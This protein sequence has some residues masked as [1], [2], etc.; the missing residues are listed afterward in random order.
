MEVI[1]NLS[2]FPHL[3]S[4]GLP[5][6]N[7]GMKSKREVIDAGHLGEMK[8]RW[9]MRGFG[10]LPD[11]HLF[12]RTQIAK[13]GKE[14]IPATW[15][16]PLEV[17]LE[18][19][20]FFYPLFDIIKEHKHTFP[21]AYGL[22]MAN[23]GMVMINEMISRHPNSKYVMTDW[24]QFDK[25]IP[26]WLIRDAFSI[27]AS[28]I[29]FDHLD[30]GGIVHHVRSER[31]IRRWKLLINYSIDTPI[32]TCKGE[33]FLISGGVPSGSC[34]T[35]LIDS[36]INALVTRYL[37]YETTGRYAA[38]EIF[39]GDDGVFVVTRYGCGCFRKVWHDLERSQKLCYNQSS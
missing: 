15:G 28:L 30:V 11:V 14:K 3:K 24:S 4:P 37:L 26:P 7:L 20:R 9:A 35:N 29:D 25:T 8:A 36:V 16:F 33:R 1:P 12:G 13:I 17:Y 31:Q 5:W 2:D 21:I 10:R 6:K 34:F 23:G 32:R 19:A 27:L 39:L 18:E 38:E 22:E